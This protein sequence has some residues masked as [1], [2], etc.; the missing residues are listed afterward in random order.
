M[1]TQGTGLTPSYEGQI[2]EI[3]GKNSSKRE[4]PLHLPSGTARST[5]RAMNKMIEPMVVKKKQNGVS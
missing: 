3:V 5:A 2:K 4:N 1:L